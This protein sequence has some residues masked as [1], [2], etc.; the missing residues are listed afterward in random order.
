MRKREKL[1]RERK[2]EGDITY[3]SPQVWPGI[4]A[5]PDFTNPATT[6]YWLQQLTN[7]HDNISFDGLWIDMNE[8]SNFIPGSVYGC[9]NSTLNEPPFLP[10]ESQCTV[11]TVTY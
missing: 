5:Y 1:E 8:P 2:R 3:I 6:S 10:G 4:T 11:A 9:P 7:F